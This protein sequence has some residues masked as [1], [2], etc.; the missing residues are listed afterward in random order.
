PYEAVNSLRVDAGALD[1]DGEVWSRTPL[2]P[3]MRLSLMSEEGRA[4]GDAKTLITGLAASLE[5]GVVDL[6]VSLVRQAARQ[7]GVAPDWTCLEPE[8]R[9]TLLWVW[10]NALTRVFAVAQDPS[11]LAAFLSHG[12]QG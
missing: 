4:S 9:I 10:A 2:L 3:L 12:T 6:F 8:T 1:P 7:A 5:S 11:R